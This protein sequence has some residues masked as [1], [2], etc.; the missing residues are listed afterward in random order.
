MKYLTG[1][2][3]KEDIWMV[4]KHMKS[5]TRSLAVKERLIKN[6]IR[7]HYALVKM[8]KIRTDRGAWVPQSVEHLTLDFSSGHDPRVMEWRPTSGSALSVEPA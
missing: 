4:S 5:C 6:T 7:N 2:F 8:A 1:Y 3:T